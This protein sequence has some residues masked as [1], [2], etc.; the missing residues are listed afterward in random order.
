MTGSKVGEH[1]TVVSLLGRC[2]CDD[3]P[4]VIRT[5]SSIQVHLIASPVCLE[6]TLNF[7]N[8]KYYAR[9]GREED[10]GNISPNG[11]Y[12]TTVLEP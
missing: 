5:C 8:H 11:Y 2:S 7:K 12:I 10:E 4:S 6:S 9:I 1:S 3:D